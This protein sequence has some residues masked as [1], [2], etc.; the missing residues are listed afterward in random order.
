MELNIPIAEKSKILV[1]M[2]SPLIG[3]LTPKEVDIVAAIAEKQVS[4]LDKD[5]RTIVR[6][7][8]DMDKFNFNNYLSKLKVKKILITENEVLKV[9]PKIL[10]IL[11]QESFKVNF[12]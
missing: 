9:N 3:N 2:I 4:I 6:M 1:R 12:V 7:F 5:A 10:H 8:L 11:N